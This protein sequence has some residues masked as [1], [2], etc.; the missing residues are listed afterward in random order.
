MALK[1]K[2]WA[3]E[4]AEVTGSAEYQNC[5]V[6]ITDPEQI[7]GGDY[8]YDTGELNPITSDGVVFT[9]QARYIPVRAGVPIQGESQSNSTTVRAVRFQLPPDAEPLY[10]RKGLFFTFVDA[11]G[12]RSLEGRTAKITDDFQGSSSA[13]RTIHASMDI[14][15]G[16]P[17]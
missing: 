11:P 4:I 2:T 6:T 13:T 16:G 1:L 5:V 17:S 7:V 9:G 10:I 3:D 12:N 8:N 14:D 15:A